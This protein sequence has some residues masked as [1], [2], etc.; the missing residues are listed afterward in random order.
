M[1]Y[2]IRYR[3]VF[4]VFPFALIIFIGYIFNCFDPKSKIY[5]FLDLICERDLQI[6]LDK[7][8]MNKTSKTMYQIIR[9][10]FSVILGSIV[11]YLIN[12]LVI[13]K[14]LKYTI[15]LSIILIVIIYIFLYS[16]LKIVAKN[17]IKELNLILPYMMKNIAYLAY[18]YPINNAIEKSLD[19]CPKEF[20]NDMNKLVE[21]IYEYP[22]SYKPFQNFID[23]YDGQL[24]QLDTYFKTMFRMAKSTGDNDDKA[25]ANLNESI[26]LEINRVRQIKNDKVNKK[27]YVLALIPVGLFGIMLTY[28][29]F[30]VGFESIF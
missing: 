15:I 4:S 23:R 25:L 3:I 29:L 7:A 30:V 5:W 11:G 6:W 2:I 24:K 26:S 28:L 27:I 13:Q 12:D 16:C 20:E 21:D 19:Y 9:I 10:V 22:N 18:I 8:G 1:E 17:R 14:D